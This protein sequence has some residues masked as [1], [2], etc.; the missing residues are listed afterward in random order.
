MNTAFTFTPA[1]L[2]AG[3][4]AICAGISCIAGAVGWVIKVIR[5]AR[6]PSKSLEARIIAIE[7]TI[8]EY[9][10]FFANDKRR[11]GVIEDGSRVTQRAILALLSHAIDGNDVDALKEAKTEL[12]DYL[13]ART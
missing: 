13:I 4:L 5:A 1:S 9:A 8:E 2:I 3:F 11:L 12:Q 10:D 6:A 7:K